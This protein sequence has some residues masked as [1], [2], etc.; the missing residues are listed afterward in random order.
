[1]GYSRMMQRFTGGYSVRVNIPDTTDPDFNRFHGLEGTVVNVIKDDAG[2]EAGDE[3]DSIINQIALDDGT[4][5][6]FR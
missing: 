2:D 4:P 6:D 3:R 1:M 5:L